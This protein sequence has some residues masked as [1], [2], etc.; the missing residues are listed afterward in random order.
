MPRQATA[1]AKGEAVEMVETAPAPVAPKPATKLQQAQAR[2]EKHDARHREITAVI[3]A[4]HHAL[5]EITRQLQETRPDDVDTILPLRQQAQEIQ[6]A[7]S[8]VQAQALAHH[9]AR[10]AIEKLI[11][12]VRAEAAHVQQSIATCDRQQA[13][14][15][16]EIAAMEKKVLGM[17]ASIHSLEQRKAWLRETL[18]TI[19]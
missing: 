12:Q 9:Q 10:P 11:G 14:L 5:G 4:K 19:V 16:N 2:L 15:R 7:I 3:T 17:R 1:P 8:H 13:D 18:D 6:Q